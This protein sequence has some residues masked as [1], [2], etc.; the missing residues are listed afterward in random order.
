LSLSCLFLLPPSC[1]GPS[2]DPAFTSLLSEYYRSNMWTTLN[3]ATTVLDTQVDIARMSLKEMK[4][5]LE[6][7][8]RS[9]LSLYNIYV[10]ILIIPSVCLYIIIIS[11]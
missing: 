4:D 10:Y 2:L 11:E 9:A 3:A 1:Y 5:T 6:S 8:Y 7:V